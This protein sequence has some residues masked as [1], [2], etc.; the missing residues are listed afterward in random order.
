M[1]DKQN[2]KIIK[3]LD[4]MSE[5][6]SYK[7]FEFEQLCKEL[8]QNKVSLYNNLKYLKINDYIDIK[9]QDD[10]VV[11]LTLL[12]KSRQLQEQTSVKLYG[13]SVITRT[14]LVSGIFNAIMAFLGAFVALLLIGR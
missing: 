12:S 1:L 13:L 8:K 7:V 10:D 4:E 9:Y 3:Y 14:I 6:E 5:G 11:C 2:N